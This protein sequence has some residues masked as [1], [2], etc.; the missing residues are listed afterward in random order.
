[1][2]EI[3]TRKMELTDIDAVLDIEEN[4]FTIPWTRNSFVT[5]LT[6]N[7]LSRYVVAEVD[8]VVAAYGGMWLIVDEAH[9]TNIA[10]HPRYRGLGVGKKIV[11][12]LLEE[13]RKINI[14]RMTLEVR[15][16]NVVAQGL[17]RQYGFMPCG[18]RPGY[19]HDNGED[20]IIMWNDVI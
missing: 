11:E 13:G 15:S 4:S 17:Y 19:Y 8:G 5:E 16:S 2:E 6:K 7:K 12:A 10:V 9:I 20:A 3:I 18:V 1:M 14:Y